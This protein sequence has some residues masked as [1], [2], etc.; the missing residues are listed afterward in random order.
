MSRSPRK[1]R[2]HSIPQ[3]SQRMDVPIQEL[4]TIVERTQLGP[5][6]ATEH[7]TLSAAVNTLAR[8]TQE[9]ESNSSPGATAT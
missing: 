4:Q 5:L 9:L 8:V 7:A 6:E 2:S 1:A 3:A